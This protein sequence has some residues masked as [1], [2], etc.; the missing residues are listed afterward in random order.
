MVSRVQPTLL[1]TNRGTELLL[2]QLSRMLTLWLGK[3]SHPPM[4]YLEHFNLG[5]GKLTEARKVLGD[6]VAVLEKS[7]TATS[8]YCKVDITLLLC[9]SAMYTVMAVICSG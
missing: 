3:V 6:A 9:C 5:I 4:T 8:D 7:P 2:L 1:W